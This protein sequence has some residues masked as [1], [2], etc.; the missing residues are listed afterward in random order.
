MSFD[1][2]LAHEALTEVLEEDALPIRQFMSYY[3]CALMEVETKFKV[4]NEQLSLHYDRNPIESIESRIK[5][6]SSIIQ[7]L[8]TR[9]LPMTLESI[10]NN[11][12][13][14]A[15]VRVIASFESDIY[16]LSRYFLQQDD[17]HLIQTKDYIRNPK[18]NGYR[19]LHLIVEVPI[20]L[21]NEKRWVKVEV[22]FRTIAMDFWASLEHKIRYKK[23]L[24]EER[25]SEI[26]AKL[27]ECAQLCHTLDDTMETMKDREDDFFV[28]R[29][30]LAITNAQA[31]RPSQ[32]KWMN[33][34]LS[35]NK[36]IVNKKLILLDIDGTIQT[37]DGII[38]ESAISAIRRARQNGHLVFLVTGRSK[39][40]IESSILSIGFDGMICGNGSYIEYNGQVIKNKVFETKDVQRIIAYLELHNLEF[41][42]EATD[43][44]YGSYGFTTRGV[45]ALEDYG[46]KNPVITSVYPD[47]EFPECLVQP[48]ITKI[49]YI[50]EEYQ[51]YLG[52]KA[53]FPE[54]QCSTWGG[55]GETA[56]FGDCFLQG[57][58][59]HDAIVELA[60]HLDFVRKDIVSLGDAEVDIPMFEASG[61]SI[62]MG[63]GR[64]AAKRA[65]DWIT[66]DTDNDGLHHAFEYFNLI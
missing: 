44:L 24:S 19:S 43:G 12:F 64:E 30:M 29:S 51:D 8:R 60:D 34:V 23:N 39:G 25:L 55:K 56:I 58:D 52:F 16:K 37:Y 57:I 6:A 66:Y 47:M 3:S 11:I 27:F 7:K 54:F 31:S 50:L 42:M 48:N 41:F 22:Q 9:E 33:H 61:L 15:G 62:C 17:V 5:S 49:N 32:A 46:L 40:H 20:F 1:D 18:F 38:P 10:E 45:K 28:D 59:K 53:N 21:A 14:I 26:D 35:E 4:L 36:T 63:S 13:D 2:T 65:A